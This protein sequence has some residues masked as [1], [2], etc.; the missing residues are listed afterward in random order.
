MKVTKMATLVLVGVAGVL[1]MVNCK[2]KAAAEPGAAEKAGAAMDRAAEHAADKARVVAET[3][4]DAANKAVDKTGA[5]LEK[6]GAA[7]ENAGENLQQ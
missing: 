3:T 5:A 2:Q 4:K 6:A 1:A 7:I